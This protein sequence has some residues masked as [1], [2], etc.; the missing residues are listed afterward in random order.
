[1]SNEGELYSEEESLEFMAKVEAKNEAIARLG[2]FKNPSEVQDT[3]LTV[4]FSN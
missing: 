1:L 2:V 4:A 3:H